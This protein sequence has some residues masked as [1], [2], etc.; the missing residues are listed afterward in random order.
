[1]SHFTSVYAQLG[2]PELQ[3]LHPHGVTDA[4]GEYTLSTYVA[5]DGAPAGDW[6]V[7]LTKAEERLSEQVRERILASGDALPDARRGRYAGPNRSRWQ[8][9][10]APGDNQLEAIEL[11]SR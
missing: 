1:M 2:S 10:I 4:N 8:V 5:G 9:T 6:T 7:T 3:A 11:L